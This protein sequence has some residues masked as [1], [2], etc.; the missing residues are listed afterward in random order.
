MSVRREQRST[1]EDVKPFLKWPGGK[2]WIAREIARLI[3]AVEPRRYIEP[4][5]G[6]GAVFFCLQP[7][8]ALLSDVNDELIQTYKTVRS[9]YRTLQEELRQYEVSEDFYYALRSRRPR[10]RVERAAR[11]LYLNRTS[12]AGIYR[13]NGAGE[14]NV[15]YGGGRRTPELLTDSPILEKASFT[16][17]SA[18]LVRSDFEPIIEQ[19]GFG[20][21]VYCDPTYTVA[22]ESN[23]FIRY[24]E[25]NF[26]WQDQKRLRDASY[27]AADRGALVLI[28][29]A[30]HSCIRRLYEPAKFR[31]LRRISTISP[32]TSKR[33]IVREYLITLC[34]TKPD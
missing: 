31:T 23:G 24:N 9:D 3:K 19:A 15:P 13:T 30:H 5:L 21:A 7:T 25:R 4:F 16:L 18:K 12:F 22:H 28:S 26:S 11:L 8:Q 6:G 34:P 1:V 10:N 20:D 29:N 33:R 32:D 27:A 17:R 2:R 14:F